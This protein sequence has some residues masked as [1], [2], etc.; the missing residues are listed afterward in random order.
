MGALLLLLLLPVAA[1]C[2][3]SFSTYLFFFLLLLLLTIIHA[4]RSTLPHPTPCPTPD[5]HTRAHLHRLPCSLFTLPR[6]TP[7]ARRPGPKPGHTRRALPHLAARPAA[8]VEYP[9]QRTRQ[10]PRQHRHRGDEGN[11]A[12]SVQPYAMPRRRATCS[13]ELGTPAALGLGR[14]VVRLNVHPDKRDVVG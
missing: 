6:C 7:T 8:R 4:T 11:Q 3:S 14:A 10:T 2:C 5:A 12:P 1:A 13:G 9:A